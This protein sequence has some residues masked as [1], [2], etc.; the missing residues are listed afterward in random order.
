MFKSKER[1]K[2]EQ[3]GLG[4]GRG[5]GLAVNGYERSLGSDENVLKLNS[6]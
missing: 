4:V 2:T 6:C 5:R 3:C 1:E